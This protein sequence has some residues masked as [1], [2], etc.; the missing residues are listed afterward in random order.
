MKEKVGEEKKYLFEKPRNV[1]IAFGYFLGVLAVLLIA[2]FFIHKHVHL[3]WEAWPEFYAV[4]G[5]VTFVLIVFAA[6][7]I[8]RPIVGRREDYYD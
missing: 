6:K 5:F 4:F 1:K 8:L 7:Y 3:P 2:E